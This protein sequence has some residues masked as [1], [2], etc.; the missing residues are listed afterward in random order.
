VLGEFLR[1]INGSPDFSP[2][3]LTGLNLSH[4]FI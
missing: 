4:N 2:D 3:F 1:C